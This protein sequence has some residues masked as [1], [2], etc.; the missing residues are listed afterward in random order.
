MKYIIGNQTYAKKTA[1]VSAALEEAHTIVWPGQISEGKVIFIFPEENDLR[2]WARSTPSSIA[3]LFERTDK[4]ARK[5]Q[6]LESDDN[7][8]SAY[9]QNRIIKRT[10]SDI[11]SLADR[12]RFEPASEK[13]LKIAY[14][15]AS[16][17]E[18]PVL[19]SAI[20]YD[21]AVPAG[22][23]TSCEGRWRPIPAGIPFPNLSWIGF[24]DRAS[25]VR[26]HGFIALWR[27]RWFRGRRVV[28]T[29]YPWPCLP[30]VDLGFDN[31]A[32]SAIAW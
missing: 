18:P 30:L 14:E 9:W 25:A 28:L 2:T 22:A 6:E 26:V 31:Q 10:I 1:E 27:H 19:R 16:V 7:E 24:N 23:R 13:L 12:F 4:L 8:Q 32:S 15:G 3:E 20:L 11:Q 17:L 29:G 5:A 21:R